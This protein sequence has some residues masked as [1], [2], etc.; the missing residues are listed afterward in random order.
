MGCYPAPH[1][2]LDGRHLDSTVAVMFLFLQSSQKGSNG[3]PAMH[4]QG[5]NNLAHPASGG[6]GS[7][8]GRQHFEDLYKELAS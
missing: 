7:T 6:G 5:R 2:H 8:H 3:G 1:S 4:M